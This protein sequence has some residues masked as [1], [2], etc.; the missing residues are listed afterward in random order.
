MATSGG[1]RSGSAPKPASRYPPERAR[2]TPRRLRYRLFAKRQ[3]RLGYNSDGNDSAAT[4]WQRFDCV[5]SRNSGY[6][7]AA[8]HSEQSTLSRSPT[9][10]TGKTTIRPMFGPPPS[11]LTAPR[12][13]TGAHGLNVA[14]GAQLGDEAAK[15]NEETQRQAKGKGQGH[16]R[17]RLKE[18]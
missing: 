15:G 2:I 6:G 4:P 12:V 1:R 7:Y 17:R 10:D 11:P 3:R 16:Q 18:K 13:V 14:T 8:G 5:W 9:A